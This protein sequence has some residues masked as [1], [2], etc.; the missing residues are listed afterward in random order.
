MKEFTLES[1]TQLHQE[2]QTALDTIAVKFNL[3]K[4]VAWDIKNNSFKMSFKI[5]AFIDT[6][7][8]RDLLVQQAAKLGLPEI[9]I[10]KTFSI[11][12]RQM[13]IINFEP[14]IKPVV[15]EDT[16]THDRFILSVNRLKEAL[17]A[18]EEA[19]SN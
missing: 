9:V 6:E 4:I 16:T 8:D 3:K 17:K 2:I 10:D 11:S 7:I 13:R 12:N 14:G 1:S 18:Q 5:D 15:L 19:S